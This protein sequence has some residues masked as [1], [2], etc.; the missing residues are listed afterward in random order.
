VSLGRETLTE[1]GYVKVTPTLQLPSHP[2]IFAL[3]DIIDWKEQKQAV[4]TVAHSAVVGKNIV[5]L[6]KGQEVKATYKGSS[7]M[8]VITL[9]KVRFLFFGN[10]VHALMNVCEP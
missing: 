10:S 5:A 9:G 7:E 1:A 6:T 8:I 4:K 2:N 3:G